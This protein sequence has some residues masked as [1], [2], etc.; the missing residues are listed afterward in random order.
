MYS[1]DDIAVL[2]DRVMTSLDSFADI[3]FDFIIALVVI[4]D[5]ITGTTSIIDDMDAIVIIQGL[6]Y[7]CK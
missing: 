5:G 4:L 3:R 6:T 2:Y 1:D 7:S